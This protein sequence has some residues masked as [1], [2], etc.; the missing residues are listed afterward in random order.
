MPLVPVNSVNHQF[1]DEKSS[2]LLF[3]MQQDRIWIFCLEKTECTVLAD[4][5]APS[6]IEGT[7]IFKGSGL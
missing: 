2:G 7:N 1:K 5:I 3:F 6:I 4:Y